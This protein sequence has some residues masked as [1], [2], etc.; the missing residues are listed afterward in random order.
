MIKQ[1]SF[2]LTVLLAASL[3]WGGNPVKIETGFSS[4]DRIYPAP[5]EGRLASA[6]PIKVEAPGMSFGGIVRLAWSK[7]AMIVDL[8]VL[9]PVRGPVGE[10]NCMFTGDSV[11]IAIDTNPEKSKQGYT[12]TCFEL[13]FALR[14]KDEVLQYAWQSGR[15]G[16]FDWSGVKAVGSASASGYHLNISLPWRSLE[17]D[18]SNL[19]RQI[20]L[21]ILFN[22][23]DGCVRQWLEWTP[24]IGS[25]KAPDEYV[26]VAL[27]RPG[28]PSAAWLNFP[29]P[30]EYEKDQTVVGQY[31]EYA[32]MNL[33]EETV[34]F[35]GIPQVTSGHQI[36]LEQVAL[37]KISAGQRRTAEVSFPAEKLEEAGQYLI[38]VPAGPAPR[39]TGELSRTS[40][41]PRIEELLRQVKS[42][43][44]SL[45]QTLKADPKMAADNYV[46]LG[47]TI[48]D[49]FVGRV[50]A[51]RDMPV[52]Q[53]LQMRETVWV[54][55]QTQARIKEGR[56]LSVPRP[57]AGPVTI[58]NGVFYLDSGRPYYFY[59]Y[60]HFGAVETD[61]PVFWNLGATIIQR[62][63]GPS[64]NPDGTLN[65]GAKWIRD[66]LRKAE[67]HRMKVDFLLSPHYFP[68][69]IPTFDPGDPPLESP[70][71]IQFN[72]DHPNARKLIRQWLE[73]IVPFV[74]NE[75][76]L[77]SIN[78]SNEPTY[79]H[80][81]R[82][83]YSRPAWIA[84]LKGRHQNIDVLNGL[85]G[86]K[87]KSFDEV[88]VPKVGMPKETP[89]RRAYYDWIVF[90]QE[91]FA[92]WHGWMNGIVKKIAPHVPTSSKV[93]N[94]IFSQGDLATGTDPELFCRITDLAG[95]DGYAF[96]TGSSPFA[97]EW[98]AEEIWYDLLHSFRGRPVFNSENHLIPDGSPP[99]SIPPEHTYSVFWQGGLH[100]Q[101]ATTTWIWEEPGDPALKGSIYVRPGNIFGAGKAMFDLN[102]L[103]P[104]VAAVNQAPARVA[105]LYSVPS[106]FWEKDYGETVRK[107]Y[108]ELL[109]LGQAVTFVSERQL[110]E[111]SA[112]KVDVI[113]LP[114]ASH[115]KD[116]TVRAL[117][118]F[119]PKLG[120]VI[121]AASECLAFDEY[122]HARRWAGRVPIDAQL[123]LSA[124]EKAFAGQLRFLLIKNGVALTELTDLETNAAAR[125]IEYRI[126]ADGNSTLLPM[127]NFL[128]TPRTVKLNFPGP[129]VDLISGDTVDVNNLV[130]EPMKP[131]LLQIMK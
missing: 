7:E 13:G 95:N 27:I 107:L 111:G 82:D 21:N 34:T 67:A 56:P 120:K 57:I 88:P 61:I 45:R 118:A 19:P 113:F 44:E 26:R 77:F 6:P 76:G 71:F 69:W 114:H 62:E 52:W 66:T 90:N 49:R 33:P 123:D 12:E 20:G 109:F 48:A 74:K 16:H 105:I 40:F 30:R 65:D 10:G 11:Q 102:R 29:S 22:N 2:V 92:D 85:Y 63:R 86:T 119:S 47:L 126:V 68:H 87:Y 25:F 58:R 53:L 129:A 110:A 64:V 28:D 121:S 17:L 50:Q 54:L 37:P 97:Y 35:A 104:Q 106:I 24:G 99:V 124:D 3:A 125:G 84:F 103:A 75:P 100:H 14:G 59:G 81:G 122:H 42:Q 36:E 89:D 130:L 101:G 83:K 8:E 72:I 9:D 51:N 70:G 78:L 112:P 60:G 43:C 18:S 5:G 32:A 4:A 79:S 94:T 117:N 15:S 73:A 23:N 131:R 80:S 127:V 55:D 46:T 96:P 91:H 1:K 116:S 98:A 115:V 93:M 31:T 38:Q 128:T 41:K 108:M 39:A